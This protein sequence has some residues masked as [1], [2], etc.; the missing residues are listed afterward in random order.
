[1]M[2]RPI[3]LATLALAAL[4]LN[5]CA[6]L[7]RPSPDK[8]YF[9]LEVERPANAPAAVGGPTLGVEKLRIS[10]TYEGQA[11]VYRASTTRVQSDFYNVFFAPPADQITD[12]LRQWLSGNGVFSNVVPGSSALTTDYT[13]EGSITSLYGDFIK[14]PAAVI[15]VEFFLLDAAGGN[16]RV[17]FHKKYTQRQPTNGQG[18]SALIQGW[19]AALTAIF[20]ELDADLKAQSLRKAE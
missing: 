9:V 8:Q 1:M 16:N 17:V 7:D 12:N 15:E 10:P 3:R 13:L 2:T 14:S 20:T 4:F 6:S 5:S 19:N 11:M 18:A